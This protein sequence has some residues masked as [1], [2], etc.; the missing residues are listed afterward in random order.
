MSMK[1]NRRSKVRPNWE[2]SPK[3]CLLSVRL[4]SFWPPFSQ[5]SQRAGCYREWGGWHSHLEINHDPE[6]VNKKLGWRRGRGVGRAEGKERTVPFR[7]RWTQSFEAGLP[8]LSLQPCALPMLCPELFPSTWYPLYLCNWVL[9]P[10]TLPMW[11]PLSLTEV[12]S[13]HS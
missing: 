2:P 1:M 11:I 8:E 6:W 7:G 4:G 13:F 12:P 10:G 5:Y 9:T 3:T